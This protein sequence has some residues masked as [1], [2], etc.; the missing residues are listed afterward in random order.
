MLEE[1]AQRECKERADGEEMEEWKKRF[2]CD[3]AG[4]ADDV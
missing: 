1:K 4:P 2:A 3:D